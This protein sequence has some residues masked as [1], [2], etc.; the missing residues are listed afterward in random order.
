MRIEKRI[1]LFLFI[2]NTAVSI[3]KNII[4]KKLNNFVIFVEKDK[5]SLYEIHGIP[6]LNEETT[7][8]NSFGYSQHHLGPSQEDSQQFNL[9]KYV[10]Q[11]GKRVF[12]I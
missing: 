7:A 5:T 1:F 8:P 12:H 6:E 3:I 11:R 10:D 4:I 9:D 2:T